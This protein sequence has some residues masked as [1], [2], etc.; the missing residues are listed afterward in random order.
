LREAVKQQLLAKY[1]CDQRV[2]VLEE[3]RLRNG[4]ARVDF[5]VVDERIHGFELKSFQSGVAW[6]P[7]QI[8][9]YNAV[10][11]RMTLVVGHTVLSEA[12]DMVPEWW[13]IQLAV[14]DVDGAVVL[15]N[16]RRARPNP[17]VDPVA[18]AEF[19][20]HDEAALLL[21]E[22][23]RGGGVREMRRTAC[24]VL[25]KRLAESAD[26]NAIWER[27]CRQLRNPHMRVWRRSKGDWRV[28][29]QARFVECANNVKQ[30]S[31]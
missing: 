23:G 7:N 19:L 12:L 3:L 27:V 1:S 20:W 2:T 26:V 16:V 28:P 24:E 31:L 17:A 5:A 21:N 25:Y 13:G 15:S 11:D 10:L 14:K 9:I 22:L 4:R 30:A 18:V 8:R 6:L 29:M